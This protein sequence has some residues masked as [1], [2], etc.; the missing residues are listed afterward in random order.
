MPN[1]TQSLCKN[2]YINTTNCNDLMVMVTKL[3]STIPIDEVHNSSKLNHL[4]SRKRHS[5]PYMPL[6]QASVISTTSKSSKSRSSKSDNSSNRLSISSSGGTMSGETKPLKYKYIN[7]HSKS[8][9]NSNPK[10]ISRTRSDKSSSKYSHGYHPVVTN[11]NTNTNSRSWHNPAFT[12][13]EPSARTTSNTVHERKINVDPSKAFTQSRHKSSV[14]SNA[15]IELTGDKLQGQHQL[16]DDGYI[17]NDRRNGHLPPDQVVH[18]Q[19]IA[20]DFDMDEDDEEAGSRIL[21]KNPLFRILNKNRNDTPETHDTTLARTD[22][23]ETGDFT[24]EPNVNP[25]HP[26]PNTNQHG[27]IHLNPTGQINHGHTYH[28][29]N[30]NVN[31]N[32][33]MREDIYQTD[34]EYNTEIDG[35]EEETYTHITSKDYQ[36]LKEDIDGVSDDDNEHTNTTTNLQKMNSYQ[37]LKEDIDGLSETD[38]DM[39]FTNFTYNGDYDPAKRNNHDMHNGHNQNIMNKYDEW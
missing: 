32:N 19:H 39:H 20:N 12:V 16:D 6:K 35:D 29:Q 18:S 22:S 2:L 10:S 5:V 27:H 15:S 30:M 4:H 1:N 9:S 13:I 24:P 31:M 21:N 33:N 36:Q 38:S 7:I 8:N 23:H 17:I 34:E 37:K 3:D 14:E 28:T 25:N 26:N 11:S